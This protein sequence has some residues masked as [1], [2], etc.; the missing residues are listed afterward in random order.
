MRSGAAKPASLVCERDRNGMT[1]LH[2]AAMLDRYD[3]TRY[4]MDNFGRTLATAANNYG[5]RAIHFACAKGRCANYDVTKYVAARVYGDSVPLE[6]KHQR[7][8]GLTT[9]YMYIM[10]IAKI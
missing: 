4:L 8:D 10:C 2:H 5:Q 6:D 7:C 3:V 1:V 9:S